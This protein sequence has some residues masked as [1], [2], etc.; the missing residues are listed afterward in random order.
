MDPNE[1]LAM[2]RECARLVD[3]LGDEDPDALISGLAAALGHYQ[4]LDDW[5]TRGGFL[6]EAWAATAGALPA[7]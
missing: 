7:I 1:A 3:A 2:A 5:I 4:A 6:P